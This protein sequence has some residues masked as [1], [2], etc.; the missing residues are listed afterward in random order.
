MDDP[1]S[2][3]SD[4][5]RRLGGVESP[6]MAAF[7]RAGSAINFADRVAARRVDLV[8]RIRDGIPPLEYLPASDG[9]LVRGRRHYL[10][11]PKKVGKSIATLSHIV[12]IVQA[13]GRVVIF[14]RENGGNLYAARLEAIVTARGLEDIYGDIQA[15]L[16]YYEFPRLRPTD[17]AALV[18]L[19][20]DADLVVL[21]SQ[22]MFITDLGFEEN[23]ND[24]YAAFMGAL[25][26]PLFRAGIATLIL[27]NSGH[28][29]PKRG[30]GASTKADLN[31]ILFTL[32]AIEE[33]DSET[34][35]RL[36]LEIVDS[37]FGN[38]GRWEME[39][40]GGVFGSWENVTR[41]KNRD[42]DTAAAFRPTTLMER[43]SRFV[44][45]CHEPVSRT[46]VT[47]ATGGNA[48]YARLAIDV[49]VI[50]H[51]FRATD[52]PRNAKLVESIRPYREA[53]DPLPHGLETRDPVRDPVSAE[54][55]DP[56]STPSRQL[57]LNHA[58][59]L[60]PSDPVSTASSS[61]TNDPVP[62]VGSPYGEPPTASP[63]EN[64]HRDP[65]ELDLFDDEFG[66][67]F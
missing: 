63:S 15:R 40:G 41:G 1:L 28:N 60:T 59:S 3:P 37:R 6:A 42:A 7:S 65:A 36:R 67:D 39:I 55:P 21:D 58:A 33:F 29:E 61:P 5:L 17:E 66:V 25:I 62:V 52:G 56:V 47:N 53:D 4:E 24:D 44:E 46:T 32:E 64:G 34:T 48:Q 20:R 27:D 50:E 30:R 9:M 12:D 54:S 26:D 2:W 45:S 10:P 11:A 51:Y 43:A 38:T 19:C 35:G 13:G 18:E 49:L 57:S 8:Q 14:D 31:E 23:S 22:R 16:A